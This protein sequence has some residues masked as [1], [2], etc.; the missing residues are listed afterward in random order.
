MSLS[1]NVCQPVKQKVESNGGHLQKRPGPWAISKA[2]DS[3]CA[4][5]RLPYSANACFPVFS[6]PYLSHV[7]ACF[8][9]APLYSGLS[10]SVSSCGFVSWFCFLI[11]IE[12]I[13]SPN[14]QE[15]MVED[16]LIPPKKS[17]K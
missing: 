4:Q 6:F 16:P 13:I 14:S 5:A 9:S 11:E 10:V 12:E 8:V 17:K 1:I 2:S 3:R 7:P 15:G